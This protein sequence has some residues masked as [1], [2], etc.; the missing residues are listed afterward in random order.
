MDA[1]EQLAQAGERPVALILTLD[2]W[3]D[4]PSRL[5]EMARS[6]GLPAAD[7]FVLGGAVQDVERTLDAWEVPRTRDLTTG[8][9]VH[10]ALTYVVDRDGRIAYATNGTARAIVSLVERL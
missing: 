8:E 4:T 10:P 6:W 7:A 2:P 5:P 9:V 1:Q 3:R